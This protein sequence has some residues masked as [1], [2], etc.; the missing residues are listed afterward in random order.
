MARNY[1]ALARTYQ[2]GPCLLVGI[3][4]TAGLV[5]LGFFLPENVPGVA[6]AIVALGAVQLWYQLTQEADYRKHIDSGGGKASTGPAVG[7]GLACL[8]G[9]L[10]AIFGIVLVSSGGSIFADYGERL[11][12]NGGK[13]YY[14]SDVTE[15][16]ATS[17][18]NYLVEG[19]F[20]DNTEKSVQVTR[21]GDVYEFRIIVAKES[22]RNLGLHI[23]AAQLAS[24]LSAG[25]FNNAPVEVHICDEFFETI[26]KIPAM[27]QE[28]IGGDRRE[29]SPPKKGPTPRDPK[30][31]PAGGV[32]KPR[33][34]VIRSGDTL[35]AIAKKFGV[36]VES[37]QSLNG[38]SNPHKLSVGTR[39][40]IPKKPSR[41]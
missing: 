28:D 13:L 19:G 35:S 15:E 41:N 34:Y 7:V 38:I 6:L 37:L 24:E 27:A 5:A 21:S 2:A 30:P 20:F 29:Q 10:L 33:T 12:F 22:D 25:V 17:L 9:I 1:K 32:S 31:K 39:L 16:Q 4:T 11:E 36:T 3:I 40:R 18:G 23:A 14:K 8:V 26:K